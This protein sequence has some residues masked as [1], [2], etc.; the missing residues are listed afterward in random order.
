M[1]REDQ[2]AQDGLGWAKGVGLPFPAFRGR[3][4]QNEL[5]CHEISL[6]PTIDII[7]AETS[8][9]MTPVIAASSASDKK[10]SLASAIDGV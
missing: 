8:R 9:E 10:F 3:R 5:V 7:V 4:G 6:S 1:A 2:F